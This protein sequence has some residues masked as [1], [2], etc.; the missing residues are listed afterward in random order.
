MII[1][2]NSRGNLNIVIAVLLGVVLVMGGGLV[3]ISN[4]IPKTQTQS[5]TSQDATQSADLESDASPSA[6][7]V[8]KY[9]G[10]TALSDAQKDQIAKRVVAPVRDFYA[11]IGG[12]H[13]VTKLSIEATKENTYFATVTHSDG[14]EEGFLLNKADDGFG[15]WSPPCQTSCVFSPEFA[16]KYPLIVNPGP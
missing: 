11:W 6:A 16:T 8:V 12:E 5:T 4:R 14:S 1:T 3:Y 15:W 9:T 10:A 2:M 7:L 13:V